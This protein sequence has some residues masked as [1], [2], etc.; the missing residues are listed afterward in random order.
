MEIRTQSTV[1]L[2]QTAACLLA[3]LLFLCTGTQTFGMVCQV[4][5][6]EETSGCCGSLDDSSRSCAGEHFCCA[7]TEF[8]AVPLRIRGSDHL[9]VPLVLSAA[10][11]DATPVLRETVPSAVCPVPPD[12]VPSFAELVLQESLL[13]HAPPFGAI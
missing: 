9:P 6:Q 13:S 8:A 10:N 5:P 1:F 7:E 11:S 4:L 3:G 2:R 12:F